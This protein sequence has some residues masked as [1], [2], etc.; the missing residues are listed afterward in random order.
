MSQQLLFEVAM[1]K[2]E[3]AAAA[4]AGRGGNDNARVSI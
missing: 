4:E 1:A 2:Q 3:S